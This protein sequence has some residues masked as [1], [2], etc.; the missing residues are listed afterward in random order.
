LNNDVKI[1]NDAISECVK[2]FKINKIA[3]TVGIRLHFEDNTVQ[4]AGVFAYTDSNTNLQV[5][6]H[7]FKSHHNFWNFKKNLVGNTG[8]FLMMR[9]TTFKNFGGFST[10]YEDCLEDVELNLKC[11]ISGFK[12]V[13]LG[14][15]VAYHYESVTRNENPD[16]ELLFQK[17]FQSLLTFVNQHKPKL[18]P[19]WQNIFKNI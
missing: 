11:L 3:G 8:A 6:H 9:T 10:N 7:H 19:I 15:A 4:H 14:N 16:K 2:E 12:N 5:G 1:L 17:D 13:T 18:L